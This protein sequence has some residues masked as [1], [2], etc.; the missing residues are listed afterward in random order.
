MLAEKSELSP[1]TINKWLRGETESI[2]FDDADR[3]FIAMGKVHLWR[4]PF[5]A[6]YYY[7]CDLSYVKCACPGCETTFKITEGRAQQG[8][9]VQLYCSKACRTAAAKLREGVTKRRHKRYADPNVC[10][11]NHPKTPENTKTRPDGR[12][13]CIVCAREAARRCYERKTQR[14]A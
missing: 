6:A 12:T 9:T 2:A 11:N 13:E 10:R 5:Y 14:A 7:G 8:P 4:D 1:D 3:V